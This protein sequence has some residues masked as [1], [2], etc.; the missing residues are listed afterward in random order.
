MRPGTTASRRLPGGGG[1]MLAGTASAVAVL[2]ASCATPAGE[3]PLPGPPSVLDVTMR[4]YRFDHR[5]SVPRGWIVIRARNVGRHRHDLTLVG[6][7]E[8]SP[9]AADLFRGDTPRSFATIADLHDLLP[10]SGDAFAVDLASGR[11]AM[12]CFVKGRRGVVHAEGKGM[13]SEFRVR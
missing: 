1:R 13:I 7:P 5:T 8:G 2:T 11:Y 9:R 3:A 4:D 6:L 12:L 10:G